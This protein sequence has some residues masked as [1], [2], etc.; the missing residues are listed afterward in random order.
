MQAT[1]RTIVANDQGSLYAASMTPTTELASMSMIIKLWLLAF[2]MLTGI[3]SA[4]NLPLPS[5]TLVTDLANTTLPLPQKTINS[6]RETNLEA[7]RWPSVPW[8]STGLRDDGVVTFNSYK[9]QLRSDPDTRYQI[10]FALLQIYFLVLEVFDPE[11]SRT[12]CRFLRGVA[13][14]DVYLVNGNRPNKYE[15]SDL[16]YRLQSLYNHFDGAPKEIFEAVLRDRVG[17]AK[18]VFQLFFPGIADPETA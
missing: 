16:L 5:I 8:S 1:F 10:S 15:I 3:I 12:D 2:G 11:K 4:L 17:R 18:M 7:E 14:F 6:T 9:R 13:S